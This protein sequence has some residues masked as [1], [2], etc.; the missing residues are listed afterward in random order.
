MITL[1]ENARHQMTVLGTGL[2]AEAHAG[3]VDATGFDLLDKPEVT[4]ADDGTITL[5]L[6]VTTTGTK[7]AGQKKKGT[8][9][10]ASIEEAEQSTKTLKE[11][12]DQAEDGDLVF[13]VDVEV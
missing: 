11:A 6:A 8:S 2:L 5:K 7:K 9:F 13:G 3:F 1:L 10:G 4:M 12:L